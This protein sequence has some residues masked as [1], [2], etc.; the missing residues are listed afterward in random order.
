MMNCHFA[1]KI[2][3]NDTPALSS[4]NAAVIGNNRGSYLHSP[5]A[6][7]DNTGCRDAALCSMSRRK[8][9]YSEDKANLRMPLV[10]RR[11]PVTPV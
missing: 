8:K 11:A 1:S 4:S 2:K 9:F 7:D 6:S 10:A 5:A 3:R